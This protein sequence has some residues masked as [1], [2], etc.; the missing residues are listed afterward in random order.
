M[1]VVQRI[2]LHGRQLSS[3]PVSL[4]SMFEYCIRSNTKLNQHK[5]NFITTKDKQEEKQK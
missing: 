3:G 5:N 4:S 1:N 2:F